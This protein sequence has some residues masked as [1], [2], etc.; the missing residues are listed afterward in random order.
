MCQ[1]IVMVNNGNLCIDYAAQLVS[2][3]ATLLPNFSH[4]F[5]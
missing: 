1:D 3:I 4:M 2:A 5:A